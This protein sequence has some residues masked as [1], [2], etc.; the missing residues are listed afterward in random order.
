MGMSITLYRALVLNTNMAA[1]AS[2]MSTI[3][4]NSAAA[5]DN[6]EP[7]GWDGF[8]GLQHLCTPY[9]LGLQYSSF[10]LG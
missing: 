5:S 10:P 1:S 6:L 7:L 9:S 4:V 3:L 8:N 2:D